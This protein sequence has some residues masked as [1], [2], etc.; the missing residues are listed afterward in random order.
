MADARVDISIDLS[1]RQ[2]GRAIPFEAFAELRRHAPL[3]WYEPGGYWVVSSYDLLGEIN[4]NPTVFSSWGGPGGAGTE[5]TPS[6]DAPGNRTILTMDPPQHTVYRRLVSRSF[7]PRAV[8]AREDLARE[9]AREL[10]EG[11]V[12]RGGGDWVTEVAC[13]L[14]MRVMS[15]LMGMDRADE[16]MILRRTNALLGGSDPEY[17]AGS[18][19]ELGELNVESVSYADRLIDEHRRN[20]RHD[21]VDDL[22]NARVDGMPLSDEELR[23]WVTMYIGGGAETTRHLIAHGLVCLLEWPDAR[24]QVMEGHDL[25]LAVEEMLRFVSPVMHHSRWPLESVEI[26]GNR[27]EP[28]QRTTLWMVSANR[29]G[30]AFDDPDRFDITRDPNRHDSLG[31]GGP[32]FCL[33]A[34]LARLEARVLFEETL[35][36]LDRMALAGPTQRGENNFFNILK[37]CPVVVR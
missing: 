15:S 17:S 20:P 16:A 29:D 2:F 21:L 32:H 34:G 31:A 35:P 24:R 14:P 26:D 33:G 8:N 11:F 25:G 36:Y 7:M 19:Q 1:H 13:L 22:L 37:H 3:F 5:D 27:I 18:P 23:A 12:G 10:I 6:V 30:K 4:R 28:G 9:M